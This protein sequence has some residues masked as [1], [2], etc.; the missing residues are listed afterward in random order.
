M[1]SAQREAEKYKS[2]RHTW[3]W[4]NITCLICGLE[5]RCQEAH[6]GMQSALSAGLGS[7]P[8]ACGALQSWINLWPQVD[9]GHSKHLWKLRK[10]INGFEVGVC[11]EKKKEEN[12]VEGTWKRSRTLLVS[13]PFPSLPSSLLFFLGGVSLC[14]PNWSQT[15]PS[16]CLYVLDAWIT[17]TY[18]YL[19]F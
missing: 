8:L 7:Y 2:R 16:S 4:Y 3:K 15:L 5:V 11:M 19:C 10:C 18:A 17:G 9:A 12:Y 13:Q 14:S 1:R 6:S